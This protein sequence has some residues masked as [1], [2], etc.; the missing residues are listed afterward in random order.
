M[1]S[2]LLIFLRICKFQN[3]TQLPVSVFPLIIEL[4]FHFVFFSSHKY[5]MNVP[6]FHESESERAFSHSRLCPCSNYSCRHSVCNIIRF[7]N[8]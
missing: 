4:C 2:Y 5:Q 8:Q 7:F 1:I 3:V 6:V